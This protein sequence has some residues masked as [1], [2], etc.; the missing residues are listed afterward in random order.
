MKLLTTFVVNTTT[1]LIKDKALT[2]KFG[3]TIVRS[4]PLTSYGLFFLRDI[5]AMASAFTIPPYLGELISN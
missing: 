1:S 2:Q 4:F 3:T 5:I